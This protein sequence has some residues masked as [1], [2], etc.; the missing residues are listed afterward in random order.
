MKEE[1]KK[2]ALIKSPR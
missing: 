1:W 2:Y